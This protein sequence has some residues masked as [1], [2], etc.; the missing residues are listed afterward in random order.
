MLLQL[1]FLR[2]LL[3]KDYILKNSKHTLSANIVNQIFA[4]FIFLTIPNIL[5]TEDYAQTVYI[6]VLMSFIVLSGFGMSFVYSR[7]MPAIYALDDEEKIEEF[8]Q[9]FFWFQLMMSF[10]GSIII[11][12][13]YYLKYEN[14]LN[15]FLLLFL[16]PLTLLITFF[17]Q[18]SSVQEDFLRYKN[19]NIKKSVTRTLII[20]MAYLFNVG[21]WLGGQI[22]SSIFVIFTIKEKLILGRNRI[23]L[24]IIKEHLLE[25]LLLL[26]SFFFWNQ[27]LNSGRL[28]ATLNYDTSSIA[29]YGLTNAGYSMLLTLSI[30]IFLPV[31]VASLKIMQTDTK[32]AIEQ[33]FNVI[34]KTSLVLSIV[35]ISA[36]EIAPYLYKIFFP[37]Y[38]LDVKILSYQLLS[39]MTLPLIATLGNVFIGLKAPIKIIIINGISFILSY[40]VFRIFIDDIHSAAFAQLVGMTFLGVSLFLSVIFFYGKYIE[41]RMKKSIIILSVIFSPYIVYFII[42]SFV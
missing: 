36:I 22:V 40:L 23:K 42:R 15:S 2:K 9:T 34:I 17:I 16:Y 5:S 11:C 32:S 3:K 35:V 14:L 21:G 18:K 4:M 29:L 41:N 25:G 39:L 19:I 20:P 28:F 30:S 33:L 7:I 27:L 8:N 1:G 26:A 13:I 12:I 31:T 24:S 6:S 10:M 38:I 37:A